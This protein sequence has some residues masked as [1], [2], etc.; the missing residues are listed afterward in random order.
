MVDN[1]SNG[2]P[3]YKDPKTFRCFDKNKAPNLCANGLKELAFVED[4]NDKIRNTYAFC[5]DLLLNL[6]CDNGGLEK[7]SLNLVHI[8]NKKDSDVFNPTQQIVKTAVNS[9]SVTTP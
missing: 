1:A 7:V 4:P 5:Y 6:K 3:R 9:V 2:T 8:F